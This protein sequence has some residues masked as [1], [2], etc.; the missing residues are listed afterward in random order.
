MIQ[1]TKCFLQCCKH[2][3]LLS[4]VLFCAIETA[5]DKLLLLNNS[6]KAARTTIRS[7]FLTGQKD[8]L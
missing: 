6:L 7:K 5:Q 2:D 8:K 1:K 4:D 3:L